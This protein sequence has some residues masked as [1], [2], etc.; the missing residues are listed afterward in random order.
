MSAAQSIKETL[1]RKRKSTDDAAAASST[2]VTDTTTAAADVMDEG[3]ESEAQSPQAKKMATHEQQDGNEDCTMDNTTVG[4]DTVGDEDAKGTAGAKG[5]DAAA[6][7]ADDDDD[8]NLTSVT[9][10]FESGDEEISTLVSSI[11]VAQ[12]KK[13]VLSKEDLAK[14]KEELKARMKAKEQEVI[15][16]NKQ[17]IKDGV[18]L[19]EQGWKERYYG[20]KHKK[21]NIE[22]GGGLA[23]MCFTYVQGLCWVLRYYYEGVPSWNWYYPFHYAPFASDLRNI[24]QYG[25]IEFEL[26]EPFRPIEQLL[27]VFPANSVHALPKP[28]HWLMT[29]PSSPIIDLYSDDVALDPNGK[30]LP[31]LWILLLPFVDETRITAAFNLCKEKLSLEEARRNAFGEQ[32]VFVHKNSRLGQI[33]LSSN[34]ESSNES[35]DSGGSGGSCGKAGKMRYVPG[36]EKDLEV[37]SALDRETARMNAAAGDDGDDSDVAVMSVNAANVGSS[38]G[39]DD[40]AQE[41]VTFDCVVGNGM[42]GTL[43]PPPPSFFAPLHSVIASPPYCEGSF[44]RITSNEVLCLTYSMPPNLPHLSQLL[45]GVVPLPSALNQY[46]LMPRR[47]PRL[48]RGGFN[49]IDLLTRN[50]NSSNAR[51]HPVG[52][53]NGYGRGGFGGPRHGGGGGEFYPPGGAGYF[54]QQQ[55][56]QRQQSYSAGGYGS[57]GYRGGSNQQPYNSAGW[58]HQ[59]QPQLYGN[60][61]R[62]GRGYAAAG[63]GYNSGGVTDLHTLN[64]SSGAAIA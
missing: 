17:T 45:P 26:S 50:N 29:D 41:S 34:N 63:G 19:H 25:K 31:W 11:I 58:Q 14:A 52:G 27:A 48:N 38:R 60:G 15:D 42:A 12:E 16:K 5:D 54:Q 46:D 55:Q 9:E 18:R 61:G 8:D 22:S 43:S 51:S 36:K 32:V 6:A 4:G 64:R 39:G 49:I 33:A 57:G 62:G 1:L 53:S 28:C 3:R 2:T 20:E 13:K 24:D 7:A 44:Q 37:I 40:A 35:N 30:H 59:S 23:R 47:P 56:H 10:D 21:E